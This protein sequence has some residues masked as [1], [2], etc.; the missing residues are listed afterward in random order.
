MRNFQRW[1]ILGET[2]GPDYY[3]GKT[4]ADEI[5]YLKTWVTN[6]MNWISAQFA[7]VPTP[8]VPAGTSGTN[9]SLVLGATAGQVYFT[10]DGTDPRLPGGAASPAAKP[11]QAPLAITNG[12]R[13][14]ART[15]KNGRWSSPVNLNYTSPAAPGARARL[16]TKNEPSSGKL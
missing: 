15:Q 1:P 8:S 5:D 6:R 11:Y 13:I 7:P 12:L 3:A 2:V 14:V 9:A 10:I 4:Y 16:E